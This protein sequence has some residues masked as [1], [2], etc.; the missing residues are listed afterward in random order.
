MNR[1]SASSSPS[2]ASRL[3]FAWL[4][5]ALLALAGTASALDAVRPFPP[6]AKRGT[7]QVV[8]PPEVLLNGKS[9]RL[10]PGARIRGTNNLLVMS[11]SLVGDSLP[12]NYVLDPHGLLHDVWILNATEAQLTKDAANLPPNYVSDASTGAGE[13][14]SKSSAPA[15]SSPR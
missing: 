15:A 1:C 4:A 11:A 13:M 7:L 12:V 10:S 6:T 9:A 3:R 14:G 8:S 2:I 5:T